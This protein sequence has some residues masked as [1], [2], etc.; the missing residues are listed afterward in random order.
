MKHVFISSIVVVFSVILVACG[1]D[2]CIVDNNS[3]EWHTITITTEDAT[4]TNLN[5]ESNKVEWSDGD[6]LLV[7]ENGYSVES[8]AAEVDHAGRACFGVTF[9]TSTPPYNYNGIYPADSHFYAHW[10]NDIT[11]LKLSL[12]ATQSSSETSFDPSCD[13]LIAKQIETSEQ[14]TSLMMR[15]KRIVAMN[16]LS[17]KGL[18]SNGTISRVTFTV[19]NKCI[20]GLV[21]VNLP[22]GEVVE[23]G[24]VGAE[25]SEIMVNYP[26]PI[27]T[28]T[29][30]YF[31][32]FPIELTAGDS[33]Y[34]KVVCNGATYTK[35]VTPPPS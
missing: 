5:E 24:S 35:H 21:T 3:T 30:I 2:D 9:P 14:P 11:S 16:K 33:F 23:Y 20:A 17:L 22:T 18:P 27:S 13:I 25:H 32:S 10:N 28:S 19:P 1:K 31:N 15:F 8:S 7:F 34:V 12:S 6:K 29:P 4:R 26:T